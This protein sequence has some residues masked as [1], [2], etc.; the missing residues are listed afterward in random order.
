MMREQIKAVILDMDGV[1]LDNNDWHLRSWLAYA[2]KRKIPLRAEE[3]YTRVFGKTNQEIILEAFPDCDESTVAEWSLEKEALYREMYLPHFRLAEGL[4]D[5]LNRLKEAGIPLGL[6][7]NAPME[8]VRF[9]LENGKIAHC[10]DI[11]VWAGMVDKPKPHPD[12]YLKTAKL[13]GISADCCL[14]VEDSPTGLLSAKAAGCIP[15][16]ITSTYDRAFLQNYSDIVT[17][18]F[19]EISAILFKEDS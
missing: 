16:A 12:I 3:A 4:E 14:V 1:I 2:E 17:D 6:A 15:V 13:L 9:T 10:F 7:S 18:S 19:S 8:N 11:T 5:F